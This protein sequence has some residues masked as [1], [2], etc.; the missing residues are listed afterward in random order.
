VDHGVEALVGQQAL[1]DV[2]NV[3]RHALWQRIL[4]RDVIESRDPRREST[5][6]RLC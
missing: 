3:E 1:A 6:S 5:G 4:W 2:A